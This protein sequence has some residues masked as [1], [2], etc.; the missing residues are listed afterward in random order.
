MTL[1]SDIIQQAFREGNLIPI[2]ASP[3]AAETAEGLKRLQVLIGSV[4]G[5]EAGE[6]LTTLPIGNNNVVAPEGYPNNGQTWAITPLPL[7]VRAV[8]NLSSAQTIN[9][10][11]KPQDGSRF[12]VQDIS[13]NFATYNLTIKPNGRLIEGSTSNIVLNTDDIMREWFYRADLGDWKRVTSLT[14]ADQMPYPEEFDDLFVIMLAMRLATR[15]SQQISQESIA[16]MERSRDQFRARYAQ[17]ICT[18]ADIATRNMS[19]QTYPNYYSS[20]GFNIYNGWQ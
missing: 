5:N 18:P 17:T 16:A 14:A 15:N 11:W 12:G 4:L 8:C 6:K 7:N 19:R 13:S 10:P 1:L 9:A 3:T 20:P 2:G